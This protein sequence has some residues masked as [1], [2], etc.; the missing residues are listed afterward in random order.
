MPLTGNWRI[1]A[2]QS[3]RSAELAGAAGADGV[4]VGATGATALAAGASADALGAAAIGR[5]VFTGG[6]DG[7]DGA[8][9]EP[10]PPLLPGRNANMRN[11]VMAKPV[12][13]SGASDKSGR[14]VIVI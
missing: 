9:E 5:A 8:G 2:C 14:L 11:S 1:K 3:G 4:N 13:S 6:A 12:C 7:D 10:P